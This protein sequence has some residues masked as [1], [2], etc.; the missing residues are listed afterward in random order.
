[1]TI[2][3]NGTAGITFPNGQTQSEGLPDPG[4]AGNV[5]T[6]NGT[7][8]TS[9][10]PSTPAVKTPTNVSPANAAT[11]VQ[12][13]GP[14]VGSTYYSL[15]GVA[16]SATQWQVS[17]S[18]SFTSPLYSSGD[19]AASTTFSI[20]DGT[21]SVSTVYY[22]RVRY[23]DADGVYSDW[24]SATS[25][26]TAAV[27]TYNV[28][29]LVIAG[30]G[31]GADAY[32]LGGSYTTGGGGGAGGYL[33]SSATLNPATAYTATVGAGGSWAAATNGSNSSLGAIATS[34][35]G[36]KGGSATTGANGGSGGG[37]AYGTGTFGAG[38]AGQGNNGGL[39]LSS[40]DIGASGGGGA[41]S[42]G[43]D[44]NSGL[45]GKNGGSGSTWFDGIARAG[46]G[47][48][49]GAANNNGGVGSQ[50]GGDGGPYSGGAQYEGEDGTAN[51]GGGGGG[52][53]APSNTSVWRGANGGSGVVIIRYA[54]A[55]RGTGGTVTSSG[56]YTYHTFTT[57]GTYTA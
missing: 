38:T 36:G 19:Q 15:Y 43:A 29:Y 40:F 56:G 50:G 54:G 13:N 8:W 12:S 23:K 25:F 3:L 17:T 11:G 33:S 24:S 52:G 7:I 30:G 18:T 2:I 4:T 1:M 34:I 22:W 48:G 16:F 47:G 9:A 14:L 42:A 26:T 39:G 46:G 51:T 6:S 31:S 37:S 28:Q 10:T 53:G 55:Q 32:N 45:A 20:P 49:G 41:S 57:T 44:Q 27:F 35:G 21:L 5:L